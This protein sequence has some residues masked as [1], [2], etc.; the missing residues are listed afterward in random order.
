VEEYAVR[1]MLYSI[2]IN[3]L[4][5]GTFNDACFIKELLMIAI[6]LISPI[7]KEVTFACFF[8]CFMARRMNFGQNIKL[9]NTCFIYGI[10]HILISQP[11]VHALMQVL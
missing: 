9:A 5:Y 11:T 10:L 3:L 8:N 7:Y 4:T 1:Y 6:L 2:Y